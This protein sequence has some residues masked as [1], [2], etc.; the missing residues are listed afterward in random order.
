MIPSS[1]APIS[2]YTLHKRPRVIS[3]VYH[4]LV[5]RLGVDGTLTSL[6]LGLGPKVYVMVTTGAK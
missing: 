2:L 3:R 6:A 5:N 1:F 4:S